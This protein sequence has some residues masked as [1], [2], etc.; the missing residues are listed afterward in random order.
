MR[1]G[2]C[3]QRSRVAVEKAGKTGIE[4]GEAGLGIFG[5]KGLG[6]GRYA[7]ADDGRNADG[8]GTASVE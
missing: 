1:Y 3:Q 2:G 8:V 6:L 4:A 5:W 7:A